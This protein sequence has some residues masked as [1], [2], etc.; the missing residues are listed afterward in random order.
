MTSR[1]GVRPQHS[2]LAYLFTLVIMY[3]QFLI[4]VRTQGVNWTPSITRECLLAYVQLQTGFIRKQD[5]GVAGWFVVI[6]RFHPG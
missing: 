6:G 1:P 4:E 5:A 3:V 2:Q